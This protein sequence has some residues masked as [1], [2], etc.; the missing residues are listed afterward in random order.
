MTDQEIIEA[1]RKATN[2]E[3]VGKGC[4]STIM[5][6]LKKYD[7]KGRIL[8]AN[9]NYKDSKVTIG[10]ITYRITRVGWYACVWNPKYEKAC[11]TWWWLENREDYM[12]CGIIDLRPD[13]VKEWQEKEKAKKQ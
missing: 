10:D 1:I 6:W 4:I 11:Y 5:G 8:T 13:Y 12:I 9:P 2:G 7:D 3:F